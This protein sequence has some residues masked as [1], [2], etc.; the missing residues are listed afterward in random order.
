MSRNFKPLRISLCACALCLGVTGTAQADSLN[1]VTFGGAFEA[2]VKQAHFDPYSKENGTTIKLETYD[3]GLAKLAGM[4]Q[5]GNPTW[6]LVDLESNDAVAACDEGLLQKIDPK[7]L[8]D[9]S[10][11][12]PGTLTPC[13]VASMVWSTIFAYDQSKLP[14]GP[15]TLADFFDTRKFPGK[16]GLRKNP[17]VVMEWALIADG[18]ALKDVHKLLATEA[19]LTRAFAKLDT[20]KG[21]IVWWEAGAQPPQ[22]L[23]DGAVVMTQA[24][25][26]RIHD[27]VK[28]EG[29][30]FKI[31]W[32]GQ[33]YDFESWG[34]PV[35]AKN[36]KAAEK[37]ALYVSRPEIMARMSRYIPY[38]PPRQ[39][40]MAHV[41]P[42]VLNDLPTA[43]ANFATA[44]RLDNTFWNDHFD[45]IN[46]RFQVW[47]ARR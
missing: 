44:S 26:G 12:L 31:V 39:K 15:Q 16:R 6:D 14:V 30:P 35:G 45:T 8:G 7:A 40:A 1:I 9:T 29:K 4:V 41:A 32:D 28:K 23:A 20:I 46:T 11:F 10:D 17:K 33:I 25:N 38:A 47:L 18:V 37:F 34:I 13:G 21:D 3:G 2:A 42:E 27:A 22:L 36:A 5:A 24:Y 19:G 43:P